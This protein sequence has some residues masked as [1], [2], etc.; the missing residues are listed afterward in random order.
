MP[1]IP[2]QVPGELIEAS[3]GNATRDR[4]VQ[5]Y[6]TTVERDTLNPSP[7]DGDLAWILGQQEMQIYSTS[8]PAGWRRY[9]ASDKWQSEINNTTAYYWTSGVWGDPTTAPPPNDQTVSVGPTVTDVD[10]YGGR[11]LISVSA[12]GETESDP[13]DG[14][15]SVE[16]RDSQG[17]QLIAPSFLNSCVFS[18]TASKAY[19]RTYIVTGLPGG[20]GE[21]LTFEAKYTISGS[22]GNFQIARRRI[23]V[24]PL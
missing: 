12:Q 16:I 11:A 9:I 1:E 17:G 5:R 4:T 24:M 19:G 7:A 21:G 14:Y 10:V 3:W 18:G 6:T 13:L 15:M 20:G 22:T 8:L 23:V 2:D